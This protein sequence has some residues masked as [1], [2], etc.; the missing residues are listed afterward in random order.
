[1]EQKILFPQ[2]VEVWYVLPAIRRELAKS[3]VAQNLQQTKIA[4][5]LGVTPAAISQYKTDKRASD[6][7]FDSLTLSLIK[8]S[9]KRI[10]K[11]PESVFGE[12]LSINNHL[13]TS[14]Q[15]CTIH[16]QLSTVPNNCHKSCSKLFLGSVAQ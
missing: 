6:I 8:Q 12:I 14:G 13:K 5:F 11:Q 1:M 15:F 7:K 3:L 16:K 10:T 2:E 4:H 9:A